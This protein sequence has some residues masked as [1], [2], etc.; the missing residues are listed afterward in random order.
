MKTTL[1]TETTIEKMLDGFSYSK[2]EERGLFGLSGKLVI[3][4]EYQRNY[5]YNIGGRDEAV[6]D[7][8]LKGLPLGLLYIVKSGER[9]EVLDGQQR[10]T[11]LGRFKD[12]KFVVKVNGTDRYFDSLSSE[13][14]SLFLNT[15]LL[16]Y[17]CEGTE[18]EIK[19][20]FKTINIQGV[21]L[22]EQELRN[23]IYSGSFV[24]EAKKYF[25]NS[26]SSKIKLWSNY[27][28]CETQRQGL[29]ETA[30][31][32]IS[33][34]NGV[35]IDTYMAMHRNDSDITEM[36]NY[37]DTIIDWAS[38]LF[39]NMEFKELCG[40]KWNMLYEAY[41][42]IGYDSK[43]MADRINTLYADEQVVNKKGIFEYVL[44]GESLELAKLL[45]VRVFDDHTIKT[46]YQQQTND[47]RLKNISNCPICASMNNAN[48]TRIYD[49]KDMD[50]DH[51]TAWS[52]GGKTDISNCQMLCKTHNRSKGNI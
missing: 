22:T 6:I 14:K 31:D 26:H 40:L 28:K 41:H 45:Q 13:E 36:Q 17:T 32:F 19:S 20:W 39:K 47:A 7:S 34:K 35:S 21:P 27:L 4:P 9:Y 15:K 11:S 49:I 52:N 3:Q 50:A 42:N 48:R 44:G 12:G 25:S 18:Q 38:G 24:T 10:I 1:D 30:L 37:F 46:V 16:I 8:V 29:L 23:A 2:E 33:S 5:I 43:A 51:V